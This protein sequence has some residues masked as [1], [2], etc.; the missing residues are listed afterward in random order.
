[1][2]RI[3]E[4]DIEQSISQKLG[5]TE[6]VKPLVE[7]ATEHTPNVSEGKPALF[8]FEST[9]AGTGKVWVVGAVAFAICVVIYVIG[10]MLPSALLTGASFVML[11]L[12]AILVFQIYK[13]VHMAG[14]ELDEKEIDAAVERYKMDLIDTFNGYDVDYDAADIL[15]AAD[16]YRRRLEEEHTSITEIDPTSFASM[17]RSMA[18]DSRANKARHRAEAKADKARRKED[19]A[20]A[21]AQRKKNKG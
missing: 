20:Y 1:M 17:L 3:I 14:K 11:V 19:K 8:K 21:K 15:T 7:N 12:S 6:E 16:K 13:R 9:S 5:K 10:I 18:A 2:A 4:V